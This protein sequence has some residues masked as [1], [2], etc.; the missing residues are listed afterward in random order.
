MKYSSNQGN[1]PISLL[2]IK[3]PQ[4]EILRLIILLIWYWVCYYKKLSSRQFYIYLIRFAYLGKRFLWMTL[5]MTIILVWK[6]VKNLLQHP[7]SFK[8]V[9]IIWIMLST[10]AQYIEYLY[11][12]GHVYLTRCW[13]LQPSSFFYDSNLF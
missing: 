4:N 2:Q 1:F 9:T 6:S 5:W 3:G 12:P 11:K 13:R 10:E 7:P 8:L